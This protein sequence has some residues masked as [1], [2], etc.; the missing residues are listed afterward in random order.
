MATRTRRVAGAAGAVVLTAGL[1]LGFAGP[2]FAAEE[3]T[4]A[5]SCAGLLPCTRDGGLLRGVTSPSSTDAAAGQEQDAAE[6]PV[7]TADPQPA[8]LI[9]DTLDTVRDTVTGLLP[10]VEPTLPPEEPT[11]PPGEPTP[12]PTAP[13]PEPEQ[14]GNPGGLPSP[15]AGEQQSDTGV[16]GSTSGDTGQ[17]QN[18]QAAEQGSLAHTGLQVP[19]LMALGGLLVLTGAATLYGTRRVR[20]ERV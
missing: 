1:T 10:G 7:R 14:P 19:D 13:Q 18:T 8:G 3:D 20:I 12:G 16:G 11:L 9:G 17:T 5:R 15:G 2:A 4:Q 6:K